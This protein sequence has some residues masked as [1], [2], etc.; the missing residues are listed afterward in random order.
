MTFRAKLRAVVKVRSRVR[1]KRRARISRSVWYL[2][3]LVNLS[4]P[5]QTKLMMKVSPI[6][7]ATTVCQES[8]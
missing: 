4:K 1:G 2:S 6:Y 8:G 5:K 7:E 3:T